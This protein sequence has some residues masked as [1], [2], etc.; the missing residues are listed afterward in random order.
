MYQ[1]TDSYVRYTQHFI[2]RLKQLGRIPSGVLLVTLDVSSLYT[3]ISNHEGILALAEH[4][5][6]DD[7]KQKIGPHLLKLLELVLHSVNFNFNGGHYL[8]TGGTAMGTATAPTHGN[9]FMD[10][11]ETKALK[12]GHL[13]LF[14]G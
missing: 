4:L 14:Y 7:E 9:L 3:N 10:R 5:R 11:F 8:Q 12:V 6:K 1:K 13:N 2:S